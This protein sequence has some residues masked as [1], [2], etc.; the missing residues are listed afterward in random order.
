M[1]CWFLNYRSESSGIVE[2][3]LVVTHLVI[4]FDQLSQAAIPPYHTIQCPTGVEDSGVKYNH[5]LLPQ[6]T[7]NDS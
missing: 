3:Q 4:L 7:T 2:L 6:G 1:L 5:I